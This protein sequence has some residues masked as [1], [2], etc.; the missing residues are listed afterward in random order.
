MLS[1]PLRK[2]LGPLQTVCNHLVLFMLTFLDC[3]DW[4]TFARTCKQSQVQCNA[5][6]TKMYNRELLRIYCAW[7]PCVIRLTVNP[8]RFAQMKSS[9]EEIVALLQR[10]GCFRCVGCRQL[11]TSRFTV[12]TITMD[13]FKYDYF[14][15]QTIDIFE[16]ANRLLTDHP[17]AKKYCLSCCINRVRGLQ[18]ED[19]RQLIAELKQ[20]G[21]RHEV[22]KTEMQGGVQ[23]LFRLC[24]VDSNM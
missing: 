2:R 6:S 21:C 22:T 5:I 9:T 7:Q 14:I 17:P 16:K 13:D 8:W 12:E 15:L 4:L 24:D 11:A 20:R 23:Y 18:L 19:D 10:F 1:P 3:L